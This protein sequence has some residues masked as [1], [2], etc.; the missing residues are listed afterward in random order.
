VAELQGIWEELRG[1]TYER[2]ASYVQDEAGDSY[3]KEERDQGVENVRTGLKRDLDDE[4]DDGDD[5]EDEEGDEDEEM[6]DGEGQGGSGVAGGGEQNREEQKPSGP[7]LETLLWFMTRGD[8]DVPRNVEYE[9][10]V[11]VKKGLEG[12]RIP[13]D[14]SPWAGAGAGPS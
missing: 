13:P 8:F 4:S 14:T 1:W 6:E 2:I 3:T 5:E 9:R 10:K 7:E 12:V 11:G